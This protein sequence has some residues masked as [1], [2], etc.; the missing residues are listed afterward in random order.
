TSLCF[1][2][3]K[4]RSTSCLKEKNFSWRAIP[5]RRHPLRLPCSPAPY[6]FTIHLNNKRSK[7]SFKPIPPSLELISLL[8]NRKTILRLLVGKA[9]APK[10]HLMPPARSLP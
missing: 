8:E 10:P 5:W 6:N 1:R 3:K 4:R 9:D 7:P 2:K